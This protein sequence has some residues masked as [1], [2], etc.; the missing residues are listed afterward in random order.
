MN[1]C[2]IA[3]VLRLHGAGLTFCGYMGQ[4]DHR[5][6]QTAYQHVRGWAVMHL[7][8]RRHGADDI[9]SGQRNNL[10]IW[11]HNLDYR[12]TDDFLRAEYEQEKVAP[13]L[14]CLSYTH[15]RDYETF[16]EVPAGLRQQ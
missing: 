3:H 4:S 13:D 15:D 14:R 11:N 2:L 5:Q 16:K 7:G 1:I 9:T 6:F 8:T 10:I 12:R